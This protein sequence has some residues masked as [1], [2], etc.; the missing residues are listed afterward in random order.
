MVPNGST[1]LLG[2]STITKM[3]LIK[4]NDDKF[5]AKIDLNEDTNVYP[6]ATGDLG[7]ASLK[8]DQ[9]VTPKVLP[10][11]RIPLSL[12]D[13]VKAEL[14]SLIKRGILEEINEPTE[15]VSQMAIVEKADGK[16]RLCIDPQQL[17]KALMREHYNLATLDDILPE[18]NNAKIFSKIDVKEAFWHVRLDSKSSKFTT[19]ITP[20]GR[21]KWN[22]LPFGLKVSSEIFQ[23]FLNQALEGISG[24][25]NVVDDIIVIG[26]GDTQ[27]EALKNHDENLSKL[28]NRCKEKN[29]RLN[30]M[31]SVFRKSE[32]VFLG[33]IISHSGIKPDPNKVRAIINLKVPEDI[34]SV[35]RFCGMVQYLSRFIPDL[36]AELQPITELTKK[37]KQF[38]W[39]NDC[40]KAFNNVK[41]KISTHGTLSFFDPKKQ[42]TLQADSSQNGLGA[43]LLQ[44]EKPIA[45][46]SRSLTESQ[47]RWAQIE[48]ELLAVVV[49]LERFD[50]YTYG[51]PVVVQNDHKPLE[52]ILNKPI[53]R[54]PK[55]LQSLM[56][57]LYRYDV[58]FQYTKGNRLQIADTL[59]RDPLPDQEDIPDICINTVGLDIPDIML[60]KVKAE[61]EADSE[62]QTLKN[63]IM[64]G[65]PDKHHI[66]PELKQ[67]MSMSDELTYEDGLLMKGERII[68]PRALR[69]EIETKLHAAH[70]G[71]DSMM[72]RA[73]DTI[74]WP[75]IA[76][77][78]KEIANSCQP[79]Q[80]SKPANQKESLIQHNEGFKP[81][82]KV[83]IDLFQIYN[84]QYL[85]MVDYYSNFIEVEPMHTTTSQVVIRKLKKLFA[86]YGV[87]KV[88]ISDCGPQFSSVEFT[89]F[90]EVWGVHHLKSSPGHHQ[91]NG[92][93]EAAVKILKNLMRKSKESNSD[94]YEALL[95]FR[96][97][98]RQD[99]NLSPAQMLFG[100]ATRTLLP[101]KE[102][103]SGISQQEAII[104]RERRQQS[105]RRHYNKTAR[106]MSLLNIGQ[107]VFY[108]SPDDPTWRRGIVY[109]QIN[110]RAYIIQGLNGARYHRNRRYIRPDTSEDIDI[111]PDTENVGSDSPLNTHQ[112]SLRPRETLRKPSKYGDFVQ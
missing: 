72:R 77:R 105:V 87:P 6:S 108:Q 89:R 85:T 65:W 17:N 47:K 64:N 67:Y 57:R 2:L 48:K 35:R 84:Q 31:K 93:A 110:L 51:R 59:S 20:F 58:R 53:S 10:C 63:Y 98:P 61:I 73:R 11:R 42:V 99:T 100:R 39:S 75:G 56:M 83:G 14:D 62:M 112:Y 103:P 41:Q 12:K 26:K 90:M 97:T 95:E 19:M 70:L 49:A 82:D 109:K 86:R 5:I 23:R 107:R 55:R 30:E 88:C 29:I 92:K 52:N 40:L 3:K 69:K 32:I 50:Q 111:F 27:E 80:E 96:N 9:H 91:S 18:L 13:K 7:E 81:W 16:I 33:H 106:D 54:A 1:C 8:L 43:V 46:S 34:S 104:R 102:R 94:P 37:H 36:S 24:C 28:L 78:I 21:F 44:D 76:A 22:R 60:N 79:C 66:L 68:I 15:W 101:R 38:L 74:Y 45:Y 25:F 71:Y 4:I